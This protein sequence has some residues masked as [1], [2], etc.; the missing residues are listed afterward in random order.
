MV[1]APSPYD[2]HS[3]H[4]DLESAA[5]APSEIEPLNNFV[6]RSKII[7]HKENGNNRTY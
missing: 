1:L 6:K 4:F 5:I 7:T 3:A 2:M